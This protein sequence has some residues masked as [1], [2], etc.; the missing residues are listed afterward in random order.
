MVPHAPG[1][2]TVG[3]PRSRGE[4]S[5]AARSANTVCGVAC[6][7]TARIASISEISGSL[8]S[9][10]WL[11]AA[12]ACARAPIRSETACALAPIAWPREIKAKISSPIETAATATLATMSMRWRR[13]AAVRLDSRYSR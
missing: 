12:S 13:A 8:G 9:C 3:R 2:G 1:V 11:S 7:S 10:A 4:A 5:S 6:V